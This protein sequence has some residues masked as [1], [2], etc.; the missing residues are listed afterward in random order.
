MLIR[1]DQEQAGTQIIQNFFG[2]QND[3]CQRYA[4]LGGGANG[5]INILITDQD[6]AEFTSQSV[7]KRAS[8]GEIIMR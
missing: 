7:E 3:R 6:Q 8:V 4:H 2:F 1:S 5:W